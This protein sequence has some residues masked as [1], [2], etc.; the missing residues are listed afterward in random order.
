MT[1]EEAAGEVPIA[2]R[3]GKKALFIVMPSTDTSTLVAA[4]TPAEAARALKNELLAQGIRTKPPVAGFD[5]LAPEA[6]PIERIIITTP[7]APVANEIVIPPTP[8]VGDAE[9]AAAAV[10]VNKKSAAPRKRAPKAPKSVSGSEE[11]PPPKPRAPR[12]ATPKPDQINR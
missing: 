7:A 1:E 11:S 4:G 2:V 10:F 3:P 8:K 6:P 9:I 5:A 12:R